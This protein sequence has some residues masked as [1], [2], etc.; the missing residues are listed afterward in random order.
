LEVGGSTVNIDN[1]SEWLLLVKTNRG[2]PTLRNEADAEIAPTRA[3]TTSNP[4]L[5]GVMTPKLSI[6]ATN[7]LAELQAALAER[8]W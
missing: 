1:P 5:R 2:N 3:V 8:S 7:G 4:A 6:S